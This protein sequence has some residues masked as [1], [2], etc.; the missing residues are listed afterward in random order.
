MHHT[1]DR[2]THTTAFVTQAEE[3]WLTGPDGAVVKSSVNGLIGTGF[4][5]RY[6][7]QPREG[8]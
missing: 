2:I 7:L 4:A 1:I 6:R 3:H 5:F 8:F